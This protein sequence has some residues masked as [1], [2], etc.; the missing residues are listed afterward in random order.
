MP[1]RCPTHQLF[2][3]PK[4]DYYKF[5]TL[6]WSHL[7]N[8]GVKGQGTLRWGHFPPPFSPF[9]RPLTTPV[10]SCCPLILIFP[11]DRGLYVNRKIVIWLGVSSELAWGSVRFEDEFANSQAQTTAER[12]SPCQGDTSKVP[13]WLPRP[14]PASK[15]GWIWISMNLSGWTTFISTH[16]HQTQVS[17]SGAESLHVCQASGTF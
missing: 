12:Q 4:L 11:P 2:F 5:L 17:T 13:V 10:L 16:T 7:M 14:L 8:S 9:L 15:E 3:L 6:A 1:P